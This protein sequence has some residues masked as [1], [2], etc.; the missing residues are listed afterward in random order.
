[1]NQVNRKVSRTVN[2]HRVLLK[3]FQSSLA[4]TIPKYHIRQMNL[5]AMQWVRNYMSLFCQAAWVNTACYPCMQFI[6]LPFCVKG[7][8]TRRVF[9]Y[10][11]SAPNYCRMKALDDVVPMFRLG[12]IAYLFDIRSSFARANLYSRNSFTSVCTNF[13]KIRSISLVF[14]KESVVHTNVT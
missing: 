4:T 1:M 11:V 13:S 8:A 5:P 7:R 2:K 3:S 14:S 12:P 6:R 9:R 10:S